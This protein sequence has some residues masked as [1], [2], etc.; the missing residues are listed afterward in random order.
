MYCNTC[1]FLG[2]RKNVFSHLRIAHKLAIGIITMLVLMVGILI[3]V[4][5]NQINEIILGEEKE[6]LES[7][8]RT[9]QGDVHRVTEEALMVI[10]AINSAPGVTEA[11][12]NRDRERLKE[13]TLPVYKAL[14]KSYDISQFQFHTPPARSFLRLH[15]P[16]KYGDNLTGFRQTVVTANS[17]LLPQMGIEKGVAGIGLRG[18]EPVLHNGQHIGSA[19]IGLAFDQGFIDHFTREYKVPA[20]IHIASDGGFDTFG[21]TI[22]E[23]T[24]LSSDEFT[25]TLSGKTIFKQVN[26]G[27]KYWAVMA[28]PLKSFSGE[29]MGVVEI[30]IDLGHFQQVQQN[31][32]I[33]IIAVGLLALLGAVL[34]SSVFSRSVSK[35][36]EALTSAAEEISRGDFNQH[37]VGTQRKDEIG[38]LARAVERMAAS[39]KLAMERF[40]KR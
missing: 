16:E 24:T 8:Q 36:I 19:E 33:R 4:S 38:G 15:N 21:S 14:K 18:V 27:D 28:K 31:V 1:L 32:I 5:L 6:F 17:S 35:P 39:I 22:K 23:K 3:P 20:A 30:L 2:G 37:I 40:Q 10:T 26:H 13:L 29:I 11:F 9:F 7:L 12:A 34:I 25:K